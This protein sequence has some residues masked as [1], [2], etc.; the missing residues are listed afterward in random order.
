MG[1]CVLSRSFFLKKTFVSHYR[2]LTPPTPCASAFTHAG[3][4][5]AMNRCA[6]GIALGPRREGP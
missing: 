2:Y 3:S 1:R 6:P 4:L 5:S